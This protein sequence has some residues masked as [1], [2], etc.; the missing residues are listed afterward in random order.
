MGLSKDQQAQLYA[1]SLPEERTEVPIDPAE[2]YSI[3]FTTWDDQKIMV[4]AKAGQNLMEIAKAAG[5][6][7]IEGI[8]DGQLEVSLPGV[9]SY[10]SP[11]LMVLP[12]PPSAQPATCIF[13][14]QPQCTRQRKPKKTCWNTRSG[15]RRGSPDSGAR[16][17]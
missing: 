6:P 1:E 2:S 7:S 15:G 10:P 13:P 8:C 12:P 5:L 4:D 14:R 11:R 16:S 9:L 17:K 3:P